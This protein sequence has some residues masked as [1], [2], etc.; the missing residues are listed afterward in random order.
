MSGEIFTVGKPLQLRRPVPRR[1]ERLRVVHQDLR[2]A[3]PESLLAD[4]RELFLVKPVEDV[5][6]LPRELRPVPRTLVE[7][8][9]WDCPI[10]PMPPQTWQ[11]R[12]RFALASGSAV[13]WAVG[14]VLALCGLGSAWVMFGGAL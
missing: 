3:A 13:D 6:P 7:A 2:P 4:F 9:G 12:V 5:P 11:E 10:L 8:Y 14:S 1:P